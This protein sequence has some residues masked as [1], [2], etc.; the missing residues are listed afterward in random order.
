MLLKNAIVASGL[1]I[2]TFFGVG[3]LSRVEDVAIK[4]P[5]SEFPMRIGEWV[6]VKG[7]FDQK[8]YDVL[9]VDDSILAD[10]RNRD[11][12]MVN[13][14]V[15]FYQSQREGDIIHSPKNC[16]PGAGWKITGTDVVE[17][18]LSDKKGDKIEAVKLRMEK[19]PIVSIVVYWFQSRGRFIASEYSQKLYLVIDSMTKHRTDGSFVRILAPVANGDEKA[20]TENLIDFAALAIPHLKKHL[21]S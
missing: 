13:L 14:Y 3:P 4:K 16:M 21:P 7:R 10:F 20:A 1:M 18:Q 6:G 15:G 17:I 9:G 8:V 19:G 2:F 12:N 5:L 11:G